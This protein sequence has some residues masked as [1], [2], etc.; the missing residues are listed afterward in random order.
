MG[1]KL[2]CCS[3]GLPGPSLVSVNVQ[4]AFIQHCMARVFIRT[5]N[6]PACLMCSWEIL[7]TNWLSASTGILG[8]Q[9]LPKMWVRLF[10]NLWSCIQCWVLADN[11]VGE[12]L[13]QSQALVCTDVYHVNV[14]LCPRHTAGLI[15]VHEWEFLIVIPDFI[16]V[17]LWS[18]WKTGIA[19]P[20]HLLSNG[21]ISKR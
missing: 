19:P 2:L 10:V 8:V 3:T 11:Y 14:V 13:A 15:K 17:I 21:T 16:L 6:T 9:G 4:R 12:M 20:G 1:E 18:I 7:P 5:N